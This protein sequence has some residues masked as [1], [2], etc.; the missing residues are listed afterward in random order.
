M[1]GFID[2][3]N[4]DS[5]SCSWLVTWVDRVTKQNG[6]PDCMGDTIEVGHVA[7]NYIVLLPSGTKFMLCA[8]EDAST[9]IGPFV[10]ER[11]I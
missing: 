6:R 2:S 10:R 8:E 4:S 5:T 7:T 3:S 11:G 9:C 1:S